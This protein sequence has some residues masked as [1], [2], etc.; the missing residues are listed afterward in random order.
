MVFSVAT[1]S[2]SIC[3][4]L[5]LLVAG[6]LTVTKA[7]HRYKAILL[8]A[9]TLTT[10]WSAAVAVAQSDF[11]DFVSIRILSITLEQ[12]RSAGWIGVVGFILFVAYR[13]FVEPS[14]AVAYLALV[15]FGMIFAVLQAA[16]ITTSLFGMSY[17]QS[18]AV[19]SILVATCGLAIVENLFR[20]AGR[21]ARW[22]LKYLCLALGII[23]GYDLV[24]QALVLLFGGVNAEMF[25][26]RGVVDGMMAPL[27]VVAAARS[28]HWPIDLHVSRRIVIHT[29]TVLAAGLY[30]L[31]MAAV[32]YYMRFLSGPGAIIAQ[33]AFAVIV[34]VGL[35]AALTSSSVH[36]RIKNFINRNFF[37]FQYDYREEWL[38]FIEAVSGNLNDST[39]PQ[40]IARALA[41]L[42]DCA[43]AA[44][45]IYVQEDRA[46]RLSASWNISDLPPNI[47]GLDQL[48]TLLTSAQGVID[49]KR[50]TIDGAGVS[51]L[52]LPPWAK[53]HPRIWLI[54]PLVYAN[55]LRGFV[56][57]GQQRAKRELNWED[58]ELLKTAG[59]QAASYI[60]EDQAAMSLAKA[61]RFEDFN[62]QFA[63]VVHDIKNLTG[64]MSLILKNAERH[65]DNPQFQ[66]DVLATVADSLSRM[67]LLL[68]QLKQ[69]RTVAGPTARIDLIVA[70]RKLVEGWRLEALNVITELPDQSIEVIADAYSI[71]AIFQH[72]VHNAAEASGPNGKIVVRVSVL[73]DLP[74]SN[75]VNVSV[76]DN[77][78][79][80]D[81]EF[82]DQK[83]FQPMTSTK[84]TGYGIG[85][86]QA[87][88]LV[89]DMG[90][91]I[92]V[93]SKP[94]EG[95]EMNV[96]LP[97][98]TLVS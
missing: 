16:G 9:C 63:F 47:V 52:T 73:N 69:R 15:A 7:Q 86:Y 93:K 94:G 23:F 67:K 3:A 53:D 91:D 38:N 92:S 22:A 56:T 21:E 48:P 68:E 13:K 4:L 64:Q 72:L 50:D 62:R 57:L 42:L 46:Y 71:E 66:K 43:A 32:G 24:L 2:Y 49:V 55:G 98:A 37:T 34:I 14:V 29:T 76:A 35:G 40:R 39:I 6:L 19:A 82:I 10:L 1:F 74:S 25:A 89:R 81:Q 88:C 59:R 30:L 12:L 5:Y 11:T 36:S 45:W 54:V 51:G 33:V 95:T 18:A 96:R 85:A 65:G 90:G 8:L 28:K 78:P 75:M 70:L 20:N 84:S 27:I 79:G 80:M 77:G 41:N 26:A 87:L 60:A 17:Q 44:A 61:R 58:Y 83:L 97:R 31:G